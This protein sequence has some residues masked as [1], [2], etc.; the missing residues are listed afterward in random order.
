MEVTRL[1][2][3]AAQLECGAPGVAF[4][5]EAPRSTIELALGP[6][7]DPLDA[8]I[9]K[10]Q[11][12][13]KGLGP[14]DIACGLDGYAVQLFA[15]NYPLEKGIFYDPYLQ[16]SFTRFAVKLL[17]LTWV[18]KGPRWGC[19]H[20]LFDV[21]ENSWEYSPEQTANAVLRLIE[22]KAPWTKANNF[23]RDVDLDI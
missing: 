2:E 9:I 19:G 13:E 5:L 23:K 11:Q 18:D 16:E 12:E 17:G 6:D 15:P 1:T 14:H 20:E 22:G 8:K 4:C 3:L 7:G 21:P 10:Q